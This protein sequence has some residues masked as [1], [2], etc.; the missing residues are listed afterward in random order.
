MPDDLFGKGPSRRKWVVAEELDDLWNMPQ[1]W[2]CGLR[3]PVVD[4]RFVHAELLGPLG[5]EQ[6]K[7]EPA[8][9]EVVAYR[10]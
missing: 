2:F 3:F 5:L 7:I 10:N 9:A 1:P 6:N 8:L 4:G